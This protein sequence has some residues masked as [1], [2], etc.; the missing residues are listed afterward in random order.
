MYEF[1]AQVPM[2]GT[3]VVKME[4]CSVELECLHYDLTQLLTSVTGTKF[5]R[6]RHARMWI[7]CNLHTVRACILCLNLHVS[8]QN[9]QL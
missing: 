8:A 3:L 1:E 4:S 9:A 7:F 5:I 6:S 2:Y